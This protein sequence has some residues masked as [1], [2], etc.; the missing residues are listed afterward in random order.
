M[1][2][3]RI[4]RYCNSSH[5]SDCL[6]LTARASFNAVNSRWQRTAYPIHVSIIY[7]AMDGDGFRSRKILLECTLFLSPLRGLRLVWTTTVFQYTGLVDC[8]IYGIYSG[9]QRSAY[10]IS[11]WVWIFGLR[12]RPLINW[13]PCGV[14]MVWGVVNCR[15]LFF[16]A[17]WRTPSGGSG[18]SGSLSLF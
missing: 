13:R 1:V 14:I 15:C 4:S 16:A 2:D 17:T 11:C 5:F 7:G 3:W 8:K 6:H 12:H 10:L 9:L 18:A